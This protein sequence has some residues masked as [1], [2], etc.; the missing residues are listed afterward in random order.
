MRRVDFRVERLLELLDRA[1]EGK[2]PIGCRLLL[3]LGRGSA[4]EDFE[5]EKRD[6]EQGQDEDR[7]DSP[8]DG[9]PS[10]WRRGS[11]VHFRTNEAA[12]GSSEVSGG[13]CKDRTCDHLRV[14]QAL[15]R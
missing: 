6:D 15:Y 4:G 14:K 1:S 12:G 10:F 5:G 11:S 13:R 3:P 2:V 9:P 7:G 8:H